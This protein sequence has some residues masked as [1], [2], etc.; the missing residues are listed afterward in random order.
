MIQQAEEHDKGVKKWRR[1][2][3]DG[4]DGRVTVD[5]EQALGDVQDPLAIEA[6]ALELTARK[7]PQHRITL[8]NILGK[9]NTPL[10]NRALV[11][12]AIFD[13]DSDVRDVALD[14]IGRNK[15]R[16]LMGVVVTALRHREN[17]VV[18]RAATVLNAMGDPAAI[19]YLIPVL[20]TVHRVPLP[21]SPGIQAGFGRGADGGPAGAGLSMGER[22]KFKDTPINNQSVLGALR[23]LTQA[24]FEYR[25]PAWWEWYIA[26]TTPQYVN[27]RRSE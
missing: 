3:R 22:P 26:A 24:D 16:D 20:T 5:L 18:N 27:L 11:Q 12:S 8:I 25:Q 13:P 4:F 15:P 9:A 1:E 7:N 17:A 14:W 10:A 23:N 19:P 6:L 21:A 2:I